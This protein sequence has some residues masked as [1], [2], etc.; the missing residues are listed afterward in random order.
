MQRS[1]GPCRAMVWGYM[2]TIRCEAESWARCHEAPF[3]DAM[4]DPRAHHAYL[5]PRRTFR[6]WLR[7]VMG[8][9]R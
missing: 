6:E 5:P 1:D 9:R 8:G 7:R 3:G 4:N 2:T